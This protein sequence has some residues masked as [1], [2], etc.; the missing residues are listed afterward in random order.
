M[1]H[2]RL[3][4]GTLKFACCLLMLGFLNRGVITA[5]EET[6]AEELVLEGAVL[7]TIES[8]SLAAQV[9]GL[10]DVL[11]V[12]EGRRIRKGER[13][14]TIHDASVRA[15]IRRYELAL[16]L[17]RKKYSSDIDEQVAIKSQAVAENEFQRAID[18]NGK[19]ANVYPPSEM[20]RLKLI[21]D[22]S[23]LETARAS[24]QREL[25]RIEAEL[26]EAELRLHQ[27]LLEKH[28]VIA[29]CDGMV[30]AMEKR[31]GEWVEPGSTIVRLVEIDKLRIEGFVQAADIS[32]EWVG[33]KGT[34]SLHHGGKVQDT[35][36]DL[37]F[38]SPEANPVNGQ[39]RVFLEVDNSDGKLRPGLHPR[40]VLKRP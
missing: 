13:V 31:A 24:H 14:A 30:V 8:T 36:A 25:A 16:D 4:I 21:L 15:Q 9:S 2:K 3:T 35:T 26:A 27:E 6:G 37:V 33:A 7:K 18:A 1:N 23:Q 34:V 22:R 19:V 20:D 38:V 17:A 5:Q 32:S 29:P 12:K 11:D 40:V 10:I 39:V 28:H